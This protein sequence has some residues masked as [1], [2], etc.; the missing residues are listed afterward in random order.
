MPANGANSSIANAES[1]SNVP[2]TPQTI[3]IRVASTAKVRVGS[4]L[5]VAEPGIS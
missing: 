5:G 3:K 2:T 1:I 4:S